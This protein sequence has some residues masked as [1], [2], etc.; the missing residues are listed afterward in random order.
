MISSGSM[1][2]L[3]THL[4]ARKA[5]LTGYYSRGIYAVQLV[6]AHLD[7]SLL[8]WLCAIGRTTVFCLSVRLGRSQG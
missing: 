8:V 6:G 7:A 2:L 3:A 4:N 5:K 1:S